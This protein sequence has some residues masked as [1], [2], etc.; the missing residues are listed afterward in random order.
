MKDWSIKEIQDIILDNEKWEKKNLYATDS[1]KCPAGLYYSL[2]GEEP[3]YPIE[4]RA[5]RRMEVGN[6][7]EKNQIEKLKSLGLVVEAQ[8]RIY[9]E[10][11][12]VSGRHDGIII[13]PE[14][15]SEEAKSIIERKKEI[16]SEIKRLDSEIYQKI[17]L[18]HQNQIERKIFLE[19]L[20]ITTERKTNLYDEERSLNQMLLVPNPENELIVLEIKSIVETG[21]RWRKKE[22]KPMEGH[23]KQLMFYLWKLKET[24]PN[25]K[26]RIIYVDCSYQDILEFNVDLDSDVIRDCKKFWKAVNESVEAET[27]L[28]PAPSIVRSSM[29]G[30]WQVNY[31]AKWCQYHD[32]CTGDPKWLEKAEEEVAKL[33]EEEKN[34]R[35]KRNTNN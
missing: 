23:T 2:T 11:H 22:Q 15:C 4:A 25:I 20:K 19:Y 24:Y 17:D 29:W 5:L 31:V 33:N 14:F 10:D 8:R 16:Y 21:F 34:A 35:R 18:Y 1:E 32:K 3:T 13:S 6:M 7:I 27:P 26:G 12:K 28:P 30:K 9:D